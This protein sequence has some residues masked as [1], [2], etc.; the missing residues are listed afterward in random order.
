MLAK[1]G[2]TPPKTATTTVH[3]D[4]DR[5]LNAPKFSQATIKAEI[6]EISPAGSLVATVTATDQDTA[7]SIKMSFKDF[8]LFAV[9][10]LYN[11]N[12]FLKVCKL[13]LHPNKSLW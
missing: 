7:V 13:P 10:K 12:W 1:D 11:V 6:M 5:N 8:C 9:L 2:G 3:I 4:V